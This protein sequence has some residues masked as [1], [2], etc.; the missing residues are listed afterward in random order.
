MSSL[1]PDQ[2]WSVAVDFD[3]VL[4]SYTSGWQG[5][6]VI[7]DPP[8]PGAIEWLA[9]LVEHFDVVILTTRVGYAG[10]RAAMTAWLLGHGLPPEK[11]DRLYWHAKP[12]ALV[13]VDDRAY[14]FTGNNWPTQHEIHK[15]RP[16]W[17]P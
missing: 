8:V 15:L 16:W 4:H 3:G 6:D 9:G 14:R 5:A 13:Y 10:G 1:P 11:H 12:K 2:R 7:P 17:K